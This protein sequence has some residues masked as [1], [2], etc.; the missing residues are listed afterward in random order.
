MA[1]GPFLAPHSAADRG[2]LSRRRVL[3]AGLAGSSLLAL[4]GAGACAARDPKADLRL[5]EILSDLVIPDTD[6]PGAKATGAPAFAALALAHG[7]KGAQSDTLQVLE[8]QLDAKAGGPFRGATPAARLAAL[9]EIDNTTV[10]ARPPSA[11]GVVKSLILRGHYTSEIG[12]SQELR[13][14]LT[15]GRFDPDVPVKPGERAWSS[16]ANARNFS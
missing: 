12:A 11:W 1:D 10:A 5:L 13:Y 4:G 8:A 2:Q 7:M 16:D 3:L 15:P 6:T 14:E 9:T